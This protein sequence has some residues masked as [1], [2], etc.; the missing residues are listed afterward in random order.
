[1]A[2]LLLI[3]Q[4][5]PFLSAF[6]SDCAIDHAS[7]CQDTAGDNLAMSFPATQHFCSSL[8]PLPALG[9]V[10]PNSYKVLKCA[11]SLHQTSLCPLVV[12]GAGQL[13]GR[14]SSWEACG[15][16]GLPPKGT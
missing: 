6:S 4:I 16:L 11:E 9:F 7:C 2:C 13:T 8:E 14:P 10:Q 5:V 12:A 15:C 3:R 1:M